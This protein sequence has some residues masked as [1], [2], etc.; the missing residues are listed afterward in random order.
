MDVSV[1]IMA[2]LKIIGTIWTNLVDGRGRNTTKIKRKTIT[3]QFN[4][5]GGVSRAPDFVIS[6]TTTPCVPKQLI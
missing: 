2:V 6:T 1:R 3:T 5:Y 4:R